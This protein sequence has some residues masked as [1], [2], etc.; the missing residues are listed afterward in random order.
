MRRVRLTLRR[1]LAPLELTEAD[2]RG[3][4]PTLGAVAS[5]I[6][7]VARYVERLRQAIAALRPGTTGGETLPA[8]QDDLRA[9]R[10]TAEGAVHDIIAASESILDFAGPEADFRATV[11]E[12]VTTILEACSFQDLAG[13]RL[14]RV[15]AALDDL[16]E[17]L[18]RFVDTVRIADGDGVLR[19]RTVV[20]AVRSEIL[21]VEGPRADA[22]SQGT[23]DEIF[24]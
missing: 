15:H 24:A 8:V 1:Q 11:T 9:V 4:G 2:R 3:P 14:D 18:V 10:L 16:S 20:D 19:R 6:E 23:V 7:A 5:E 12:R 13:Q 17:R 21:L 22:A